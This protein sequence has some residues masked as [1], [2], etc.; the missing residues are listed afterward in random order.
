MTATY[1]SFNPPTDDWAKRVCKLG[2][3]AECCRYLL[4]QRGGWSCLKNTESRATMDEWA[5]GHNW[6]AKGD[7]CLGR[8]SRK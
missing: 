3:G 1:Q 4:W 5:R 6:T 8:G 2:Q 7:N